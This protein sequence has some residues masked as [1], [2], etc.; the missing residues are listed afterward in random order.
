MTRSSH[1][2]RLTALAALLPLLAAG[3]R[4]PS[5]E[6]PRE[7]LHVGYMVC[8]SLAETRERFA[9]LSS[10]LGDRLGL[11]VVPHYINT[12]DFEKEVKKGYLQVAHTNSLVYVILAELHGWRP[13][14]GEREG[15]HGSSTAG[16]VFVPAA[17]P[18]RTLGDLKGKRFMFGPELAPMGFLAQYALLVD[19]G[20]DPELDL[21]LYSFTRGAFTHEKVVYSVLYGGYDA[22]AVPLLDLE[23]MTEEGKIS[24]QDYRIL[25]TSDYFPYCTFSSAP[26]L[27]ADR[28]ARLRQILLEL[29]RD[30]TAR[31]DGEVLRVLERAG[32]DGFEVLEDSAYDPIRRLARK[33]NMPPYQKF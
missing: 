9:P 13:L 14:A 17:S 20:L 3:C 18:L 8:N 32:V 10:Y 33:V 7:K 28:A 4:G 5:P 26:S 27:A 23:N 12:S 31:V 19:Q 25:A 2:R 6:A 15:S 24:P 21:G 11:E 30:A 29:P 16:V 22:G 1:S